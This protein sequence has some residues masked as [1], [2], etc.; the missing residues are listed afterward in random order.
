MAT[1]IPSIDESRTQAIL[2]SVAGFPFLLMLSLAWLA[3]GGVSY[4][5]PTSLAGWIYPLAGLPAMG[6]AIALERR[7]GYVPAPQPDPF[8]AL[9]LQVL[10]IQVLACPA[11]A[12][13]WDS[14]P[15]YVPVAFAAVVGAHFL[16]FEWMY[17]TRL[18]RFLGVVIAV[19][20]YVLAILFRERALHY[21]GFFVG[22]V[23]LLGAFIARSH[24]AATWRAYQRARSESTSP[25]AAAVAGGR[26]R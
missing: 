21:T 19:G 4:L 20:P 2:S 10:F 25:D 3:A 17:R 23:M 12:L 1:S 11:V 9:G 5:V 16:P 18:Y 8:V 26:I 13:V 7:I 22:P 15:E 24:A 6:A 14:S